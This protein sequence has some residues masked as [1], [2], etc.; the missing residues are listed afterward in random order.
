MY[1]SSPK[2]DPGN[3]GHVRIVEQ[4]GGEIDRTFDHPVPFFLP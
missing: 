2:A 4:I 1:R 3:D